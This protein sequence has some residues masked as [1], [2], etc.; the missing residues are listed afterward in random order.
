MKLSLAQSGSTKASPPRVTLL[1]KPLASAGYPFVAA[2]VAALSYFAIATW[3]LRNGHLHEDAYILFT[4]VQNLADGY[5]IVYFP[6][7]APSEGAT[8]FLWMVIL[9]FLHWMGIDAGVAAAALNGIGIGTICYLALNGIRKP[10]LSRH[11]FLFASCFVVLILISPIAAASFAGFSTAFFSAL[12]VVVFAIYWQGSS[13][14]LL[15]IPCLALALGLIRPEGVLIGGAYALLGLRSV[16]GTKFRNRYLIH[17]AISAFTGVLYFV[18]RYEYFGHLLPLPLYVKSHGGGLHL[19]LHSGI[20]ANLQWSALNIV[21]ISLV[22]F[23]IFREHTGRRRLILALLPL[24]L[25]FATLLAA[26]QTQ[27]VAFRF[28][29]PLTATLLVIASVIVMRSRQE[30]FASPR[31]AILTAFLLFGISFPYAIQFKS[32]AKEL[33]RWDYINYFPFRLNSDLDASATIALTEAGR[34]G[35]GIRGKKFDLVGLNTA[36]TAINQLDLD[37]LRQIDPDLIFVHT[38]YTLEPWPPTDKPFFEVT[39]ENISRKIRVNS[40]WRTAANPVRRAPLVV[41][42]Y[43]RE[44]PSAHDIVVV[45]F[46][47]RFWHLYAVKKNGRIAYEDFISALSDSFEPETRLSYWDILRRRNEATAVNSP[48]A[49]SVRNVGATR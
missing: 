46:G 11:S 3:F 7:G 14:Q 40:D 34:M 13:K 5:G 41:Y 19:G 36:D 33:L 10:E 31:S 16:W 39:I 9:A 29:A 35:Y 8:D 15:F 30:Q 43:L 27:N 4:Y 49:T 20:V 38:G 26:Q 2:V 23:S 17:L 6:G 28:Q 47:P 48:S 22:V 45:K 12:V 25:F 18:W 42:D 21:L 32:V 44:R 37:Y 1:R 24:L